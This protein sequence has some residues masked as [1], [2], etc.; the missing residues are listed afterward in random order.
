MKDLIKF[1]QSFLQNNGFYVF[2]SFIIEKLVMLIN[3]IFIVKM[4][5]QDEFGRITLIASVIAFI[6]P[7]NGLGSL[8]VL[9]KFGASE[10]N[11]LKR[12]DL[13]RKLF[14]NGVINQLILCVIFI[15]IAN[16]YALKFDHLLW[17]ILL[18]S[19]RLFGMFLQSHLTIDYRINGFNKKFATLNMFVN[20]LGLVFTF[21]LTINFGAIGYM[22]S[23]AIAPFISL[24][25]FSK[26]ILQQSISD[27]SEMNWKTMWKYGRMESLAYFAS[28]LLFSID[29]AMIAIFM[30]DKDIAMYKV[31]IILPM[32]LLFLPTILFQTDFPRIIQNSQNKDFLKFYIKNYYKLF[33]PLGIVILFGSYFL[34]DRLIELFFNKTY[35]AGD[36]V[37]FIATIAVVLAMLFRVLYLNLFSAIGLFNY[38]VRVSIISIITLIIADLVL[39]PFYGVEGAALGFLIMFIVSGFYATYLFKS[40]LKELK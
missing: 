11:E 30:A 18:F 40:Y 21:F 29:I 10:E 38:N 6:A 4:I 16:F 39:I 28:E 27:L 9:M 5:P 8:Q 32:N 24:F 17:I 25:F 37:F 12:R 14:R 15:V 19:I 26:S 31:A 36:T 3:T 20:C 33:I 1:I 13:S 23:L 34:S 2:L 35:L 22:I 7:W